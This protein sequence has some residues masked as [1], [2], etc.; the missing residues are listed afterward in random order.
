MRLSELEKKNTALALGV[1]ASHEINQPLTSI[2]G[3]I[4]LIKL[5]LENNN[6]DQKLYKNYYIKIDKSFAE[7]KLILKKLTS[8]NKFE[9]KQYSKNVDMLILS[10]EHDSLITGDKAL[11]KHKKQK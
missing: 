10:E 4:D 9:K 11:S 8:F 2:R 7:I 1:T 3:Y 5:I 6:I